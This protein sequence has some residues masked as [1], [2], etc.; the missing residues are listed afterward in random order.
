MFAT[1]I[2]L[3]NLGL[4]SDATQFGPLFECL[5]SSRIQIAFN[6]LAE[7]EHFHRERGA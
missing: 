6:K 1:C 7:R 5:L 4:Y 3:S 2:Q